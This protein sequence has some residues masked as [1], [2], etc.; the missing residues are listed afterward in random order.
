MLLVFLFKESL[1]VFVILVN[2]ILVSAEEWTVSLKIVQFSPG[3]SERS[4]IASNRLQ[5]SLMKVCLLLS[6][7]S[8]DLF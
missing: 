6:C 1:D 3:S 7:F 5:I 4:Y 2:S 8:L